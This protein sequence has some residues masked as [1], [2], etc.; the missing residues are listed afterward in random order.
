MSLKV[1]AI[2]ATMES[3]RRLG[4][5]TYDSATDLADSCSSDIKVLRWGSSYVC[6]RINGY[7]VGNP[8]EVIRFNVNKL[9]SLQ[10]LGEVV[11]APR[12][13]RR[14]VPVGVR[15][16]VR[17][18]EHARGQDFQIVRGPY[19][20]EEGFYGAEYLETPHE[21]RVW[22]AYDRYMAAYRTALRNRGQSGPNRAEFGYEFTGCGPSL[23]GIVRTAA[24]ELGFKTGAADVLCLDNVRDYAI[25]EINSAPALDQ[26][27]VLQFFKDAI[28]EGTGERPFDREQVEQEIRLTREGRDMA[29]AERDRYDTM[30]RNADVRIRALA[31]QLGN[32]R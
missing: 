10:R 8:A 3:A 24:Q 23:T 14:N 25:L 1:L 19:R 30:V 28:L 29:Q 5:Q 16:V 26:P 6:D 27:R 4:Y 2:P 20:L 18:M 7:D 32:E 13:F 15:A 9:E 22:F 17:P 11:K 21:Y 12:V 31:A